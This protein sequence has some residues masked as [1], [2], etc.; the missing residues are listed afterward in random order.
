MTEE[1][2]IIASYE[3]VAEAEIAQMVLRENGIDAFLRDQSILAMDWLLGNAIGYVKLQ[4]P[5]SQVETA[6]ALL[7]TLKA[8]ST[9]K[10]EANAANSHVCATCG[11]VLGDHADPCPACSETDD[12]EE[13]DVADDQ[14]DDDPSEE[15][16]REHD[17]ETEDEEHRG[18]MSR[19]RAL[20]KP[21]FLAWLL[22]ALIALALTAAALV[23]GLLSWL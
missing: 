9:G 5:Q 18:L 4:V 17:E 15:F 6:V 2:V 1:L 22:P 3:F 20:K 8:D 19:A 10:S 14:D 13:L 12:E 7:A 23:E 21:F 11:L 16:V